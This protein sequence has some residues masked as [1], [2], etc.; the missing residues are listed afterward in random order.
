VRQAGLAEAAPIAFY[1]PY[2]QDRP[3]DLTVYVESTLPWPQL[4]RELRQVVRAV[5][6]EVPVSKVQP[7]RGLV[8]ASLAGTTALLTLLSLFGIVVLLLGAIG[9]YGVLAGNV[10]ARHRELGIR[11]ALGASSR[12]L[13]ALVLVDA[14]RLCLVAFAIGIP[15]AWWSARRAE[16]LLFGTSAQDVA[17]QLAVLAVMT[18][19]A[20]VAAVV[21]AFRA[22]RVD[23]LRSVRH[24]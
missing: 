21:P 4:A 7:L 13:R 22:A 5:H 2:G 17:A 11:L 20:L 3:R 19:V 10:S 14:A 9:T 16:H 6:P 8:D 12:S 15:A 24:G 1:L 23:P 18:V